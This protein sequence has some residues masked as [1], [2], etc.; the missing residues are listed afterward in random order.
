[1]NITW[2]GNFATKII[3][4]G[5]TIIL[6]P[7]S[8][9]TGLTPLRSK[10][11]IVALTNPS[12]PDMSYTKNLQGDLTIIDTPGEYTIKDTTLIARGWHDQAGGEHNIQR[13]DVEGMTLLHLG[14]IDAKLAEPEL[15]ELEQTNIDIL[16]LPIGGGGSLNT[17]QALDLL[18]MV[19]PH[20]VIPINYKIPK[21]KTKL[22][23]V[24]QFAKEMGVSPKEQQ[25]KFSITAG[26]IPKEGLETIILST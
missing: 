17:K 18:T 22:D 5:T 25:P 3:S 2:H 12:D 11:D 4:H 6:D 26:K 16:L 13:W 15:A 24:D 19:E 8:A 10:A 14:A 7:Y 20:L 23:A 21:V 1:M 9:E